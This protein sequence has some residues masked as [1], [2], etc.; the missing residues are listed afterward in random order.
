V[1]D[2][3]FLSIV[4]DS[5]CLIRSN[6]YTFLIN[7]ACLHAEVHILKRCFFRSR[8]AI[9]QNQSRNSF[10]LSIA[11]FSVSFSQHVQ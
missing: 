4:I 8:V 3:S 9:N 2:M 11:E 1:M 5:N 10:S 7:Q 6:K